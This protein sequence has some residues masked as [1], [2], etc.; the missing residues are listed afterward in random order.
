MFVILSLDTL[1]STHLIII[2]SFDATEKLPLEKNKKNSI[3]D[4]DNYS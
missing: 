2:L 3:P 4:Y 1:T